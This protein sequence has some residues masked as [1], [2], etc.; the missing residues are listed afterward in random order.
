MLGENEGPLSGSAE[1]PSETEEGAK[2]E[3]ENGRDRKLKERAS[4][5]L[6][7]GATRTAAHGKE[8]E[9]T[10]MSEQTCQ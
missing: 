10:S 9:N 7:D 8:E 4:P 6:W 2:K 1:G 5:V 3:R